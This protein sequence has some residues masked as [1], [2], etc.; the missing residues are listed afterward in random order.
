MACETL[1]QFATNVEGAELQQGQHRVSVEAAVTV[2]ELHLPVSAVVAVVFH[3]HLG[4][5]EIMTFSIISVQYFY[6]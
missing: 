4:A 3:I 5:E 1:M 6:A 2:V